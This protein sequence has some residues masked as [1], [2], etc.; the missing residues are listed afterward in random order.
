MRKNFSDCYHFSV[1]TSG[2]P[3]NQTVEA[4]PT[5]EKQ[6]NYR[7]VVIAL[8]FLIT[9]INYLDRSAISYAIGPI[10]HEFGLNDQDFG[11]IAAAFGIGYM[12]M[13]LGGGIL[14]DR[15]GAR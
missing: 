12:V 5:K 2:E 14:V 9:I 10:K 3:V 15:W 1:Q 6:T 13:T 4:P 8:A 7:W 11:F